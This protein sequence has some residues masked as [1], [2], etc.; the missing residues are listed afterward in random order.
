MANAIPVNMDPESQPKRKVKVQA[1]P[2]LNDNGDVVEGDYAA[3]VREGLGDVENYS[4][5]SD[6]E[7]VMQGEVTTHRAIRTDH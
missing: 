1:S 7:I 3:K 6:R 2:T 5:G 4:D